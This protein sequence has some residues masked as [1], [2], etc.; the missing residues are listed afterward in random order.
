MLYTWLEHLNVN[1]NDTFCL[2]YIPT[3][4][5]Q[6]IPV[7]NSN[8]DMQSTEQ[9]NKSTQATNEAYLVELE[10]SSVRSERPRIW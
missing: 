4:Y 9:S 3:H 10:V 2:S 5:P 7:V 1:I 8:K 6:R